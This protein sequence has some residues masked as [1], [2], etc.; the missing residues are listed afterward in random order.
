MTIEER[1]REPLKLSCIEVW[2]GRAAYLTG[3]TST[4]QTVDV[5]IYA[6]SSKKQHIIANDKRFFQSIRS[7]LYYVTSAYTSRLYGS[8]FSCLRRLIRYTSRLRRSA[9]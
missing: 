7:M 2:S 9:R 1:C 3:R 6:I 4:P 5:L 8:F